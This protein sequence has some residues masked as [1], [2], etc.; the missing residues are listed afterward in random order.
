LI[1]R[2]SSNAVPAASICISRSHILASSI[3]EKVENN[4][5][6]YAS[7]MPCHLPL[8]PLQQDVFDSSIPYVYSMKLVPIHGKVT[9]GTLRNKPSP[10]SQRPS[11][12]LAVASR[13]S[14][15]LV[16]RK[17]PTVLNPLSTH[18]NNPPAQYCANEYLFSPTP[19]LVFECFMTPDGM[20]MVDPGGNSTTSLHSQ[21][22]I[23][24]PF[25][26]SKDPSA[27]MA[28][29]PNGRFPKSMCGRLTV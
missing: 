19:I 12:A 8:W 22:T 11:F 10:N 4:S 6:L 27:V 28:H 9:K 21:S 3:I 14:A 1:Q 18:W 2:R 16:D 5:I 24:P 15:L 7:T 23:W 13:S 26:G 25:T 17:L 29:H 20:R